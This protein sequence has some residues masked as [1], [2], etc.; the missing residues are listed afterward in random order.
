MANKI[1]KSTNY[2]ADIA[3]IYGKREN[4]DTG[5]LAYRDLPDILSKNGHGL[6]TL[7]F[8]CGTGFSSQLLYQAGHQ[9][10]GVDINQNMIIE[11]QRQY[12]KINFQLLT[13]GRLHFNNNQFDLILC[14]FVLLELDSQ[15]A[16][17]SILSNLHRVIKKNGQLII[18]TT[19][20]Y[21]PKNNWSSA[22]N[23]IEQNAQIVCGDNYQVTDT[24]NNMVF[25]DF[26]YSDATYRRILFEAG[27]KVEWLHQPL[28]LASDNIPWTLEWKLPPYSIYIC[29]PG[30]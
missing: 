14:A 12:P 19:S 26:F 20:E 3:S 29:S 8:G 13:N 4:L 23:N 30:E 9:V 25:S 21:F 18:I 2:N 7:D 17:T 11:A 15:K 10:T 27:F 1:I 5:M 22:L 24:N 16:M 6:K 28:G